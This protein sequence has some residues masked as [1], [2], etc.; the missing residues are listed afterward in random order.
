MKYILSI[1]FLIIALSIG[2]YFVIYLPKLSQQQHDMQQQQLAIQ[3]QQLVS[4]NF[5]KQK[6]CMAL[7][8]KQF[9]EDQQNNEGIYTYSGNL[10]HYNTKLGACLYEVQQN[11]GFDKNWKCAAFTINVTN[12]FTQE[13]LATI[14]Q[15]GPTCQTTMDRDF[16]DK[17]A[18]QLMT[19]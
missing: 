14:T 6:E 4:Q 11:A 17:Y 13:T 3:Q 1:S 19:E 5:E 10:Y 16:F 18:N 12:L 15:N 8:D 7:G 2:Y 9:A